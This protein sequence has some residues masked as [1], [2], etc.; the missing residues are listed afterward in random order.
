MITGMGL[1]HRASP[2]RSHPCRSA[3]NSNT[4]PTTATTAR[5]GCRRSWSACAR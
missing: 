5:C 4:W 1:A 3:F 2:A